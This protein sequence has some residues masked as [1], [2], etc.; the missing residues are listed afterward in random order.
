MNRSVLDDAFRHHVWATLELIDV[1]SS[2][3]PEQL[4]TSV[5][6]TYGSIL[7]TM[8]HLVGGDRGYLFAISR[9]LVP[10]LD[11]EEEA[12]MNL[13]DLRKVMEEDDSLWAELIAGDLDPDADYVRPQDDGSLSHAP[14]GV[15][16]AQV[17]H[18]GTDHRSQIC[19][20]LT[21]IGVQPPEIDVWDYAEKD[22]RLSSTPPQS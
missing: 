21:S 12:N 4:E 19:T 6:G 13:A 14:L 1:C 8:R 2:L 16:L 22:G 3:P 11:E 17:V 9:Q 5:P 20:A 7:D 10:P 15:R 18:H